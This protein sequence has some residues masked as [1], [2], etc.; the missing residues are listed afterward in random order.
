[1]LIINSNLNSLKAH[2]QLNRT[3]AQLSRSFERLS[4]GLRINGARDDAAGLQIS[5]RMTAQ[6]R[7]VQ[8]AAR[9]A[10]D[11]ISYFQTAEGALQ[12]TTQALQRMREL[13]VQGGNEILSDQDRQA[14]QGE[15]TQLS[16]E[17]N[18]INTSTQFNSRQVFSQH[19]TLSVAQSLEN[20]GELNG[21]QINYETD[22]DGDAPAD[23]GARRDSVI[24]N[25][26]SSWLR[27]SERL[28]E[29][30]FGLSGNGGTIRV[31]F[32]REAGDNPTASAAG[33][34]LAFVASSDPQRMH[35][36]LYDF[37]IGD[38]PHGGNSPLYSDRIIAHEFV[39]IAMNANNIRQ[40]GVN[41]EWFNEGAAELLHGAA[42]TRLAFR[43]DAAIDAMVADA[44]NDDPINY[45][46][47]YIA[48]AYLHDQIIQSGG[49]GIKD[50]FS[51]LKS[52]GNDYEAALAVAGYGSHNDFVIDFNANGSAFAYNLRDQSELTGDT[53]AATGSILGGGAVLDDEDVIPNQTYSGVE[54]RGGV[55]ISMQIGADQGQ[56]LSAFIGSFNINALGLDTLDITNFSKYDAALYSIDDALTYVSNQRANLGALQNRLESTISSLEISHET[57]SASR[58]RII[59]ADF[60]SETAKL[61]RAQV[62]QQASASILAQSNAS[63]QIALSLL[64]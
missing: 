29:D 32:D 3:S 2:A 10:Q 5:T 63:P 45:G 40:S 30:T 22:L 23:F 26:Q 14:I 12:E 36:D 53:G 55:E 41:S 19:K 13:V 6:V 44:F 25:L 38:Q 58:S 62:I 57:T 15:L 9:N 56:E 37:P 17:L 21:Y 8:Q 34:A 39:H 49:E 31:T 16:D 52:N 11:G 28:V 7:G 20:G 18:R 1:M 54:K 43:N 42:D 59:D 33:G 48:A 27:E 61:T 50:I 24:S 35:I 60:A 4:S 64:T 46:G 51:A 47:A